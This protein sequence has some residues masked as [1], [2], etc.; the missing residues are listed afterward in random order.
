MNIKVW[1]GHDVEDQVVLEI[2][3]IRNLCVDD[4]QR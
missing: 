4:Y 1:R 2:K 3:D